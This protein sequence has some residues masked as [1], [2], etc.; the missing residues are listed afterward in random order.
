MKQW[1][2][3][4]VGGT[5]VVLAGCRD[6]DEV[7]GRMTRLAGEADAVLLCRLEWK[8]TA[9]M[10]VEAIARVYPTVLP[11]VH[12]DRRV[13]FTR[14]DPT[15]QPLRPIDHKEASGS[16]LR[17][18]ARFSHL[19]VFMMY[20]PVDNEGFRRRITESPAKWGEGG[21][22]ITATLLGR[23]GQLTSSWDWISD[24]TATT[25]VW[26]IDDGPVP[27]DQVRN[28]MKV[29]PNLGLT[30][31][32]ISG[33][34]EDSRD[35]WRHLFD[36]GPRRSDV[37]LLCLPTVMGGSTLHVQAVLC[38][39]VHWTNEFWVG[40]ELTLADLNPQTEREAISWGVLINLN[41]RLG[42]LR[43]GS[44]AYDDVV[45]K[46]E[47]RWAIGWGGVTLDHEASPRKVRW[48]DYVKWMREVADND[49]A[50]Q[51]FISAAA[52]GSVGVANE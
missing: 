9:E 5:A 25:M 28:W 30:K 4:V 38:K 50:Y 13:D 40:R 21:W 35:H 36:L 24:P 3:A 48:S 18:P 19:L 14:Y 43:P 42:H 32:R 39:G 31:K 46:R 47:S 45:S 17:N 26:D 27:I 11:D 44:K 12:V 2:S 22:R 52:T 8:E 33:T 15:W 10:Y 7:L 37:T 16:T 49:P 29:I 23:E 1:M 41:D 20:D 6:P 34:E 51:M